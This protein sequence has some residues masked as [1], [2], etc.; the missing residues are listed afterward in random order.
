[1][2]VVNSNIIAYGYISTHKFTEA[3]IA[4]LASDPS[5]NSPLL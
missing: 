5:W 2:I 3:A 4:L 1:M